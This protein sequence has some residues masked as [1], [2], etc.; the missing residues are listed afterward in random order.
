M[1]FSR[2]LLALE[3]QMK[4]GGLE[5]V[6][7]AVFVAEDPI[8]PGGYRFRGRTL[9]AGDLEDLEEKHFLIIERRY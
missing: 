4:A 1:R 9:T 8:I 2:R 5:G 7:R 3:R 6:K